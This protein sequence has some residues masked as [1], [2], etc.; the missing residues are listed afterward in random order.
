MRITFHAIYIRLFVFYS[1][2][3]LDDAQR[4]RDW[5]VVV[6]RQG[7]CVSTR[8]SDPRFFKYSFVPDLI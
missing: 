4:W 5:G 2:S 7:V 8:S 3:F 6:E 1:D